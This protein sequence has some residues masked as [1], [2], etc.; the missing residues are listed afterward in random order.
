MQVDAGRFTVRLAASRE[1][2]E[3][4]QRLRYRV[5]VEE[6]GADASPEDRALRLERDRFDPYFDHLLLIDNETD[7]PDTPR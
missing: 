7:N 5:F 2:I 3:A 6:M 4:A 1:E